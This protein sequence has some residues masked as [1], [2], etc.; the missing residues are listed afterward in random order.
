[1]I[2]ELNGYKQVYQLQLEL[3]SLEKEAIEMA[4]VAINLVEHQFCFEG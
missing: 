2:G 1:M 4:K 3:D